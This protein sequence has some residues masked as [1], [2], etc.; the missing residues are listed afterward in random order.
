[1]KTL[2]DVLVSREQL[3]DLMYYSMRK[4][5]T[6]VPQDIKNALE[7]GFQR[8]T[9]KQGRLHLQTSLRNFEL[10]EKEDGLI[11]TDTGWPYYYVVIGDNVQIDGGFSQI[12]K[13]ADEVIR[14]CS[15]E[16]KLRIT[17]V[18]PISRQVTDR[19]VGLYFP[20]IETRFDPELDGIKVIAIPKGGGGD[21]FGSYF[22]MLLTADGMPG[23]LKFVLDRFRDSTYS[24][25]T[26]P[27]NIIGIGI[28]GTADVCMTVAKEAC[29]LRAVGDRNPDPEIAHLELELLDAFNEMG[30]G[31]MGSGGVIAAMDV[32]IEVAATHTAALAVAFN[33]QCL[34][35]RRGVASLGSDREILLSDVVDWRYQ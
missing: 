19:N 5:S 29:I 4:A 12:R 22:R 17:M 18:H 13:T 8:E 3:F 7:R 10:S 25:K 20:R 15:E 24:G 34:I 21:V 9:S 31:P 32:H 14:R 1:M 6:V 27:P 33:A 23:V 28:G 30:V 35:G 26:C 11:C 2:P 16:T